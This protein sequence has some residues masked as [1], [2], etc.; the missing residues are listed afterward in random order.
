M[1][2]YRDFY[3]VNLTLYRDNVLSSGISRRFRMTG[4]TIQFLAIIQRVF[5][6]P[7]HLTD[8]HLADGTLTLIFRN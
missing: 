4:V 1:N 5:R 7:G 3:F 2:F 8:G 6:A